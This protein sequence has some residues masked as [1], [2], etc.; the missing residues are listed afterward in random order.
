VFVN[1]TQITGLSPF[2]TYEQVIEQELAK[3]GG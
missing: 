1:D 2:E 3:A